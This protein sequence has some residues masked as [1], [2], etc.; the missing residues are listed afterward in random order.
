MYMYSALLY[1]ALLYSALQERQRGITINPFDAPILSCNRD[2]ISTNTNTQDLLI[3]TVLLVDNRRHPSHPHRNKQLP[4]R[5][6]HQ[7][8]RRL[9]KMLLPSRW[10]VTVRTGRGAAALRLAQLVHQLRHEAGGGPGGAHLGPGRARQREREPGYG[11]GA[12]SGQDQWPA[13][14]CWGESVC[15]AQD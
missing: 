2:E 6:A 9:R 14:P 1:S 12:V 5:A 15:H 7:V 3:T 4:Q 8:T 11:V 13:G 10:H